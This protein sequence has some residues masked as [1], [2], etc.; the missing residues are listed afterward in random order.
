PGSRP[1][2][3]ATT[4]PAYRCAHR[5]TAR[6]SRPP[7]QQ[8]PDPARRRASTAARAPAAAAPAGG[9]PPRRRPAPAGRAGGRDSRES[10]HA[11]GIFELS[12]DFR[13]R[14]VLAA[15]QQL[16]RSSTAEHGDPSIEP[17]QYML[18]LDDTLEY[19]DQSPSSCVVNGL[20]HHA[21]L[22][23]FRRQLRDRAREL[24]ALPGERGSALGLDEQAGA[25]DRG[26][27]RLADGER[28][29]RVRLVAAGDDERRDGQ[30]P[31]LVERRERLR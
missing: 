26:G 20:D 5:R 9:P 16:V 14:V 12:Y 25:G 11:T 15:I 8:L 6:A 2:R 7:P 22:P 31:Q 13:D 28:V 19:L 27:V 17:L 18:G 21:R 4:A 1:S 29:A 3:P 24:P 30:R 23:C 10:S